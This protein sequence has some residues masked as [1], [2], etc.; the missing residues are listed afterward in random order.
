MPDVPLEEMGSALVTGASRGIGKVVALGLAAR[1]FRVALNYRVAARSAQDAIEAIR[2]NGGEAV[3]L[4]ADV[5]D[6]D[7]AAA[8]VTRAERELGPLKILVNNA[9]VT[10]DRLLLQMSEPEWDQTWTTDL[11]GARVAAKTAMSSM[12]GRGGRIVNVGSVVGVTG[13][14]GQANY[15]AAKAALLGL[16]RELALRGAAGGIAV[17]CVV[18][19]YIVT[20]ATSALTDEQRQAWLRRIPMGRPATAEDVAEIILFLAC[21]RTNYLTGQCIAVDGGLLAL[22]GAGMAS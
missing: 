9:G 6:P 20:D 3:A 5:S 8:L 17:N 14:A 21:A 22:A 16:T 7:Q 13:N 4:Q 12:Q 2:R 1:G 18:P 15:A 10:K 11:V 19:G